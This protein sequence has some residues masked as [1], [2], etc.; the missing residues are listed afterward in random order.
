MDKRIIVDV[1]ASG[2]PASSYGVDDI[3]KDEIYLFECHPDFYSD[4][5]NKYGNHN[6]ITIYDTALSDKKGTFDFYLTQKRNCSSLREPNT[7]VLNRRDL[8][9]YKKIQVNADTMDNVLGH[10]SHIDFLK[11]DTQGSEYEI[12]QGAKEILKKT[13][14]IKCEC[15]YEEWYKGQKLAE[16]VVSFLKS[17][18]FEQTSIA[19][20]ASSHADIYFKNTNI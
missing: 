5:N 20:I 4:L 19:K 17:V 8:I 9:N 6:N 13:H 18:G 7:A 10:L 1:G 16:D 14:H 12:L 15:E 3:N 2:F 11:M